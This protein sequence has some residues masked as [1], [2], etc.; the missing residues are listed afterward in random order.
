MSTLD[1]KQKLLEEAKAQSTDGTGEIKRAARR[2]EG[3]EFSEFPDAET[4]GCYQQAY[5][6]EF[7]KEKSEEMADSFQAS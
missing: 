3:Q 6:F 4:C 5:S 2:H 1:D 7:K